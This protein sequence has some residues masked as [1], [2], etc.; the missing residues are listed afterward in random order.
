MKKNSIFFR[1][2]LFSCL[3]LF[4]SLFLISKSGNSQPT[5]Q[6]YTSGGT[7]TYTVPVGYSAVVTIEAWGAG[8]GGGTSSSGA[9]G[10]GGGG[11]YASLSTTLSAG[12]YSV[13]VITVG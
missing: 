12:N 2:K 13:T 5:S 11:A 1:G 10:G 4:I 8:G 6:T 9:K 7:Y 3:L